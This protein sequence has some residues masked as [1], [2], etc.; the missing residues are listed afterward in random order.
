MNQPRLRPALFLDRDGVINDDVGYL[1]R[2]DQFRFLPGV[3][4]ACK[5]M[6]DA[7]YV[8]VVVTNQSGIARGYY[9]E[10]H[11][12]QVTRWMVRQFAQA[13]APLAG[14]YFCPHHPDFVAAGHGEPC[15]CRKPEPG[16][17]LQAAAELGLNLAASVMVGDKE[18]DVR[19]GRAAGVGYCVR[20]A[21][22]PA[23]TTTDA[24]LCL[25]SLAALPSRLTALHPLA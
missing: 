4:D 13:G 25:D 12:Q 9:T 22:A 6:H 15:L 19:A 11:F 5:Q 20:I 7:G 2:I 3:L 1:H 16:M 23:A 18:D 14:V 8:L 17:L 24:N 21:T 10:A